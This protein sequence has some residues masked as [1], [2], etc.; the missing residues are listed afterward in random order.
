MTLPPA[1]N[2][3]RGDFEAGASFYF[4]GRP[5]SRIGSGNSIVAVF[6]PSL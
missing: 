4:F 5:R 2:D 3:E 1:S 6:H